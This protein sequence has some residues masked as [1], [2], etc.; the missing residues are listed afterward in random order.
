MS[1]LFEGTG[2]SKG[3]SICVAHLVCSHASSISPTYHP[4]EYFFFPY[5]GLLSGPLKCQGIWFRGR[6]APSHGKSLLCIAVVV[7]WPSRGMVFLPRCSRVFHA[8]GEWFWCVFFFVFVSSTCPRSGFVIHLL[9]FPFLFVRFCSSFP[10][11]RC[12]GLNFYQGV[13]SRIWPD[14][15]ILYVVRC[16][17]LSLGSMAGC[18]G[19]GIFWGKVQIPLSFERLFF[20]LSR[21]AGSALV[22]FSIFVLFSCCGRLGDEVCSLKHAW[23]VDRADWRGDTKG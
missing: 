19:S 7:A 6:R 2:G 9:S 14:T 12:L 22:A 4:T 11:R 5:F 16:L 10:S 23:L 15:L 20:G 18:S 17:V 13:S 21:V 3:N 8:S 1:A